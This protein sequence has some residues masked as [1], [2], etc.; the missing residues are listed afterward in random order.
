VTQRVALHV[1]DPGALNFLADLPHRLAADGVEVD[2]FA[3]GFAA[4]AL[5]TSPFVRRESLA[6]Y[7]ARTPPDFVVTGTAENRRT[8]AFDLLA[9]ARDAR[10]ATAAVV[11][12]PVNA[13]ARFA[14]TTDDPLA[15]APAVIWCADDATMTAFRALGVDAERLER[16]ANPRLAAL[17]AR[18]SLAADERDALRRRLFPAWRGERIAVF[19]A[20][21]ASAL[22]ATQS[23]DDGTYT[24]H[25]TGASTWRT[26][27]ALEEALAALAALPE[28][29]FV[30]VRL[31]PKNDPADVAAYAGQVDAIHAG[32]DPADVLA[33][34]DIVIGL[35][36][37]ILHEAATIGRRV[38]ALLPRERERAWLPPI[39]SGEIPSVTT[40]ED[41]RR[42]LPAVLARPAPQPPHDGAPALYD[43]LRMRL[44]QAG[45]R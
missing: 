29:T 1:E 19:A 35:S 8:R 33:S 12:L 9:L 36:S 24:L 14:G 17:R 20:E 11:D 45:G 5:A 25:G 10:I 4:N 43:A 23:H 37:M 30:V 31:H 34:A 13:A 27:I 26:H 18:A 38:L 28:P 6:D 2:V 3:D 22:D 15:F 21:P 42:T 40:R 41:L 39:A 32:G 16:I 44:R 7:V